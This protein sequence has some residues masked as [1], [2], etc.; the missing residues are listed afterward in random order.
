MYS[1]RSCRLFYSY[2]LLPAWS[3]I[4]GFMGSLPLIYPTPTHTNN[5]TSLIRIIDSITSNDRSIDESTPGYVMVVAVANHQRIIEK[6]QKR[7]RKKSNG[8]CLPFAPCVPALWSLRSWL[9][10]SH[11]TFTS[12]LVRVLTLSIAMYC[13]ITLCWSSN[14]SSLSLFLS[15]ARHSNDDCIRSFIWYPCIIPL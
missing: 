1:S 10:T 14:S 7:K 6:K 12:K 2:L 11:L 5:I 8:K 9:L 13:L 4:I 3:S 15:I